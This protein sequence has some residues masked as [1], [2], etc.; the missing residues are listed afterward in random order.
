MVTEASGG[1]GASG[2]RRLQ[3]RFWH[4]RRPSIF[5]QFSPARKRRSSRRS[6]DASRIRRCHFN[7]K[8][9]LN[10]NVNWHS[11]AVWRF[12][13]ASVPVSWLVSTSP[14]LIHSLPQGFTPLT[15]AAKSPKCVGIIYCHKMPTDHNH[16]K[17][18]ARH[19]N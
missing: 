17:L 4:A 5:P 6:P 2:L 12:G 8:T 3:R 14:N 18:V 9:R 15:G 7:L 16:N 19:L 10:V 13:G 11:G 1:R